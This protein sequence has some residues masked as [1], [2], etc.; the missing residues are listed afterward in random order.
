[1]ARWSLALAL[2]AAPVLGAVACGSDDGPG[3]GDGGDDAA[4]SGSGGRGAAGGKGSGGASQGGGAAGAGG[5]I[6]EPV[7]GGTKCEPPDQSGG[8]QAY[9]CCTP[10]DA[11][12]I[13]VPVSPDCLPFKMPGH[14]NP[15]CPSYEY[16]GKIVMPGCCSPIGCGALATFE[17]VGCIPNERLQKAHLDCDFDLNGAGPGDA[18]PRDAASGD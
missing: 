4:V 14:I 15:A 8:L 16:P 3:F 11:C 18:G 13:R 12:G 9:A 1:M 5:N 6:F 17:N 2:L 7:C 10:D